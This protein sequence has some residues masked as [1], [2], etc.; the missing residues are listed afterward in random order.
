ML[1]VEF[2]LSQPARVCPQSPPLV[3]KL[4]SV[5][6]K[7][8]QKYSLNIWNKLSLARQIAMIIFILNK[9]S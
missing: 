2:F 3:F 1:V 6:S 8:V 9:L 4:V 5:L 7:L